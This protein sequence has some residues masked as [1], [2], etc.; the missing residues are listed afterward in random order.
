MGKENFKARLKAI[1][2]ELQGK[3]IMIANCCTGGL[4]E[5]FNED[6]KALNYLVH[7]AMEEDETLQ[8]FYKVIANHPCSWLRDNRN[9]KLHVKNVSDNTWGERQ[10][11][12]KA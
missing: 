4:N 12:V 5:V 10:A 8:S 2:K 3:N 9:R 1:I 11:F 6:K 7:Q